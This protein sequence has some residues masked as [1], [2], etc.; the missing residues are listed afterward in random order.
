MHL[1]AL[2]TDDAVLGELG[3]R[4][5]RHR[6]ARNITQA[7]LAS[8]AGV[9]RATIQRLESGESVQM[10][11]LVK[12]LRTLDLLKELNEA[13]PEHVRLPIAELERERQRGRRRVRHSSADRGRETLPWQWGED[14]EPDG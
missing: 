1:A 3:R 10:T 5:E 2:Q 7:E 12:L 13:L 14:G 4:L 9:G 8:A 6:V 11:S